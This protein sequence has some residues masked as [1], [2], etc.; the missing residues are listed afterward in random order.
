M[1]LPHWP[2][3]EVRWYV[4]VSLFKRF[5]LLL[6][7]FLWIG[8]ASARE[9]DQVLRT[10][11]TVVLAPTLVKDTKGKL[12]FGLRANDFTI[13]DDGV[14]QTVQL[15]EVL[16]VQPVSLVV[17]VQ[18]GGAAAVEFERMQGLGAMIDP[19]LEQ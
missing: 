6:P 16:D 12:I 11:T 18:N 4:V 1:T 14:E 8:N 5:V 19:L 2:H 17:A 7:V 10:Q 9:Q 15:D 13:E 3:R